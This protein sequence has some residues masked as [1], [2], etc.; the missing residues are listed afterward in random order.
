MRRQ[1]LS[2]YAN[3]LRTQ[4]TVF[5]G[6]YETQAKAREATRAEYVKHRSLTD[7]EKAIFD[8]F[9]FFFLYRQITNTNDGKASLSG[10]ANISCIFFFPG[11]LQ[12]HAT[13]TR[14]R[15]RN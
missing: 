15:S 13:L 9:F 7:T 11:H 10:I 12:R 3:L 2:S 14:C 6:D 4:K 8:H 5:R 1:V